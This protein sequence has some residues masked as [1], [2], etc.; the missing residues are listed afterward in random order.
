MEKFKIWVCLWVRKACFHTFEKVQLQA[1][2]IVPW[3]E[4]A[5]FSFTIQGSDK[6]AAPQEKMN[7][8]PVHPV[9]IIVMLVGVF[10]F[11]RGYQRGL[12]VEVFTIVAF[13]LG[14]IASMQ[15][16]G[17]V[18]A[19]LQDYFT[20]AEWIFYA[21]YLLT[22]LAVFFAVQ[23]IGKGLEQLFTVTNLNII[24]RL[25]GGLSGLF[26]ILLLVS[27]VF[28]LLD[29]AEGIGPDF[30]QEVYS[31]QYAAPVAPFIISKATDV[32]PILS[33]LIAEAEAFFKELNQEIQ[34]SK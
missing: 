34:K 30:K 27:M 3:H 11:V 8:M 21:G 4:Q 26:K 23:L 31:Y 28:W 24:N 10:F 18:S 1:A 13:L 9:D 19:L 17:Q 2:I 7:A 12:I 20:N 25:L 22:F 5:M 15:L 33:D 29:Q 14:I 32:F 16:A 6:A